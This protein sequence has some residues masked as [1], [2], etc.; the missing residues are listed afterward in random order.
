VGGF[1]AASWKV[2]KVWCILSLLHCT[3]L[4]ACVISKFH[5]NSVRQGKLKICTS[6]A[7][8]QTKTCYVIAYQSQIAVWIMYKF[9]LKL[10]G[11]VDCRRK[12]VIYLNKIWIREYSDV[13]RL[14]NLFWVYCFGFSKYAI[15]IAGPVDFYIRL[16]QEYN[17]ESKFFIHPTD[18]EVNC[19]KNHFKIYIK[20]VIKTARSNNALPGEGDCT[21]TCRSCFNDNFNVNFKIFF[22]TIHLCISWVNKKLW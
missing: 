7:V 18:A 5:Y 16:I 19:L 22:K 21:E 4:I 6:Q 11:T 1:P 9:N 15:T 17:K 10:T 12:C 3:P 14:L 2:I 20:I 13:S 8:C